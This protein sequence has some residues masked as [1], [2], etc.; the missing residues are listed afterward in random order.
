MSSMRSTAPRVSEPLSD[1]RTQSHLP[2]DS[3]EDS[4]SGAPRYASAFVSGFRFKDILSSREHTEDFKDTRAEYILVRARFMAFF[5]R[6][7]YRSGYLLIILRSQQRA[8]W[9]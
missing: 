5:L 1:R 6:L 8:F 2:A 7:P 4:Q 9:M 3:L